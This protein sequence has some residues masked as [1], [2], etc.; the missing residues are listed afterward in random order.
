V[1]AF[2]QAFDET[3]RTFP[4]EA[5]MIG[6]DAVRRPKDQ[7]AAPPRA[8][9]LLVQEHDNITQLLVVLDS[10]LAAIASGEDADDEILRD[11]MAYMAEFAVRF[12]H[13][14]EDLA[15]EIAAGRAARL[16]A[17][18]DELAQQHRRI[19]ATGDTLRDDIGRALLD[20][21]VG[22][23]DLAADGFAYTTEVR[24]NMEFE[25]ASIFPQ[26]VEVLDE[27]AFAHIDAR[28]GSPADPLFGESVHDR[29][30]ALFHALTRRLDI[31]PD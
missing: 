13:A 18:Q 11:A 31:D 10:Q 2:A 12:H 30:A 23:K 1:V 20:E 8:V 16:R 22:R 5:P 9:E 25:E 19:H 26:V 29:Y 17:L 27:D 4:V 14:K 6:K 7:A 15:I 28:L 3:Q 21:P 24:R